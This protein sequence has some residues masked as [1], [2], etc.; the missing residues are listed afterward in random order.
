MIRLT[1][2]HAVVLLAAHAPTQTG[3]RIGTAQDMTFAI[4]LG[5]FMA[6]VVVL[7]LWLRSGHERAR[8]RAVVQR[9]REQEATKER[10]RILDAHDLAPRHGES[11]P[12]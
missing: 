2:V 3:A 1:V 11:A 5:T 12:R 6:L 8:R 9:Q 4:V 7:L 10:A